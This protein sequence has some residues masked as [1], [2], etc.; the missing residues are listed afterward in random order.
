[1]TDDWRTA[2]RSEMG[3]SESDGP[4]PTVGDR[5]TWSLSDVPMCRLVLTL[6]VCLQ[7]DVLDALRRALGEIDATRVALDVELLG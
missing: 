7:P 4:P 2:L 3:L 6:P 5:P 1:M